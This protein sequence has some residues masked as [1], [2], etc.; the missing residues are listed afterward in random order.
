MAHSLPH[1]VM[2]TEIWPTP[3]PMMSCKLS[4]RRVPFTLSVSEQLVAPCCDNT[5]RDPAWSTAS[6]HPRG[7]HPANPGALTGALTQLLSYCIPQV[8][9]QHLFHHPY[10][11]QELPVWRGYPYLSVC[12]TMWRGHPYL[13]IQ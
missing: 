12:V 5:Y 13:S 10:H 8:W 9:A 11:Q 1:D 7:P 3:C 4:K 6:P 2:V